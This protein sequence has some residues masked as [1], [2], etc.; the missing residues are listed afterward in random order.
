[1]S[2]EQVLVVPASLLDQLGPFSG[3]QAN[4]DRYLPSI[5]NR[6]HQSF[7]ARSLC[8]TDPSFKQLIPYVV[9][10]CTTVEG[11]K[12]FQYTRGGGSGEKRLH[13]KRSLGIGGHISIED[14]TGDDWYRTGMERELTEEIALDCDRNDRIVG[15]IYDDTTEV[16]RVHLGVV[17]VMQLRSCHA[18]SREADLADAGFFP[19]EEI[20]SQKETLETWSQLCLEHLY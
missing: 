16:G 9:L 1:M 3:F 4:V 18:K 17:H 19:I 2:D 13:A 11:T 5:L 14:T 8:E 12:L 10:E 15:L 7:I 20:K 6:K